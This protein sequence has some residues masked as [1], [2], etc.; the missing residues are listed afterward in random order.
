MYAFLYRYF[1][2][3]LYGFLVAIMFTV[4]TSALVISVCAF[5]EMDDGFLYLIPA[6][7]YYVAF[8]LSSLTTGMIFSADENK[9]ACAFF[10]STPA[11]GKA[12]IRAKY[13]YIL[14]Q[15]LMVLF[16]CYCTD[17]ICIPITDGKFTLLPVLILFFCLR[18]LLS[19]INI[20]FMIRFGSDRG[21]YIK[22]FVVTLLIFVVMIYILFGDLSW[23]FDSK[24]PFTA[25]LAWARSGKIAL[26]RSIFQIFSVIAYI[27]SCRISVRLFRKGVENY[28]K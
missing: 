17:T 3:N 12:L 25:F 7:I 15:Y 19:A 20:P 2:L 8:L 4:L 26:I 14:I 1:R 9:T 22:S 13:L 16:F 27:V 28:E 24:D 6:I 5:I 23:F 10:L 21:T 11:G 18:L